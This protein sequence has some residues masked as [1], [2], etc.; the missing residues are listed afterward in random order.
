MSWN[1]AALRPYLWMLGGSFSFAWMAAFAN[2][3]GGRCQWPLVAMSRSLLVFLFVGVS[4]WLSGTRFVFW[5][6]V[7]LW[8]R[9]LAG[10]VSV[11]TTFYALTHLPVSLVLTITNLFPIWVAIISRFVFK[12]HLSY[13]SWI[14]VILAVMGVMVIQG[15]HLQIPIFSTLAEGEK[16]ES[17]DQFAFMLALIGSLTTAIA[18]VG[19]HLVRQVQ[20]GAIVV[21]FSLVSMIVCLI[22]L[23][24]VIPE[25]QTSL[26]SMPTIPLLLLAVGIFAALGQYLLTKAFAAGPP[27]KISVVSLTQVIFGVMIDLIWNNL[28]LQFTMVLG[29]LMI[30]LPSAWMMLQNS[31][32]SDEIADIQTKRKLEIT[33]NRDPDKNL[34]IQLTDSWE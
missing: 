21:H 25:E 12:K 30:L 31:S 28:H 3:L 29:M 8:V 24:L 23:L 2:G 10:S 4:A 5:R 1:N 6:P 17:T 19:L 18:M 15:P 26:N 14:A 13:S 16:Q 11:I 34:K 20:P 33:Q 32:H 9:S 7:T 22:P 27:A